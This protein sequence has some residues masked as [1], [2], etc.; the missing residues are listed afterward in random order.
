MSIS[1]KWW[2]EIRKINIFIRKQIATLWNIWCKWITKGLF[3][4]IRNIKSLLDERNDL[5]I[6]KIKSKKWNIF[7]KIITTTIRRT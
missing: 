2:I 6:I 7:S 5:E 4:C 3:I 1:K